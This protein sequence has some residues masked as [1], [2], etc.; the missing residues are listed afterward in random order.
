[1]NSIPLQTLNIY[2]FFCDTE[3]VDRV[4]TDIKEKKFDWKNTAESKSNKK[5]MVS[6]YGYVD[7]EYNVPFYHPELFDWIEECISKVSALHYNDMKF[8]VVDSWLTKSTLGEAS[9]WHIHTNSII[10]GLLYF[11]TFKKS[12]TKFLYN[13]L[14]CEITGSPIA[15]PKNDKE[16]TINP[17]KGKLLLWRSDI[18]HSIEPHTD[19]KNTR[20]TLAFNAFVDGAV[21]TLDTARL[22]LKVLSV[23]DQYEEYM[24]KKNG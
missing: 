14:W 4:M 22:Q 20:Y 16:I 1:M 2:E 11:S 8:T 17:E 9:G 10:S 23:K 21:G 12:G 6:N 13:D 15:L 18:K 5:Q 19:M 7:E 3:L 24:K